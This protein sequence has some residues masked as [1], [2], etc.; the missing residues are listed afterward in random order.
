MKPIACKTGEVANTYRDFLKSNH[1]RMTRSRY[2]KSKLP[3]VCGCCGTSDK[4]LELHHKT[5]KRI[6]MERLNDLIL[7]CRECHQGTH[8]VHSENN[9]KNLWSSHKKF[10]KKSRYRI[11]F[12][13]NRRA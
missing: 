6:G 2:W 13:T 5:Y 1:W 7:L 10:K 9:N 11:A 4:P 8:D 12:K 3:K